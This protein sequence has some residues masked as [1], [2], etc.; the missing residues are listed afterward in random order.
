MYGED[1]LSVGGTVFESP[2]LSVGDVFETLG[3][4]ELELVLSLCWFGGLY[5]LL[6]G[7]QIRSRGRQ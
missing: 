7:F 2:I 5:T 6:G 3:N 1:W 4:S